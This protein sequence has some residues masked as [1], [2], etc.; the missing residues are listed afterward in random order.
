MQYGG[1]PIKVQDD[2][3]SLFRESEYVFPSLH[4]RFWRDS[5]SQ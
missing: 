1:T 3:Y 2:D 4:P 5:D